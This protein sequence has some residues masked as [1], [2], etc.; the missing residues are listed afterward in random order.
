MAHRL[1]MKFGEY[2]FYREDKQTDLI[3]TGLFL[4]SDDN[5]MT[6]CLTDIFF[7]TIFFIS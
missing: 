2:N 1:V 4:I 5:K 7:F 3:R 6:E